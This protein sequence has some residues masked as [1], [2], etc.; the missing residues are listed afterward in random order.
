MKPDVTGSAGNMELEDL[1]SII[2]KPTWKSLLLKTVREER[3]DPWSIDVVL[4]ASKY[5]E[6]IRKM[7]LRD[8]RIPANAV[9]ASSILVRF[10]SD[11]WELVPSMPSEEPELEE[12]TEE[13]TALTAELPVIELPKRVTRRRVTL[14]ELIQAIEQVME[15]TKR[16][17]SKR[18]IAENVI[19]VRLEEKE[20]FN[21]TIEEVYQRIIKNADSDGL[22]LFSRLLEKKTRTEV[23]KVLLSLL[24]LAYKGR[25][26]VWQE[27]EFD[28]IFV[29]LK[30]SKEELEGELL[31]S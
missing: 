6:R 13:F 1:V 10:K 19:K 27:K 25:V 30:R 21:K 9:L 17:A 14:E 4:L 26:A 3:M 23:V 12:L 8:F 7:K 31:G 2:E 5:A 20:E 29:L 28:E 24:H 22:T 18:K 11:S 15:R 16:K